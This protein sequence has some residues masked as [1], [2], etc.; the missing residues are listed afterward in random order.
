MGNPVEPYRKTYTQAE[1]V[2]AAFAYEY[3]LQILIVEFGE[4]EDYHALVYGNDP[5]YLTSTLDS[6][7]S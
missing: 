7:G 4:A 1:R 2:A 5:A 3:A 6:V